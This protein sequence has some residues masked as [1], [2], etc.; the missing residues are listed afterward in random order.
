[1]ITEI[2]YAV[3]IL[4]VVGI[5]AVVSLRPARRGKGK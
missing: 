1:M 3:I 2:A 5:C 4:V